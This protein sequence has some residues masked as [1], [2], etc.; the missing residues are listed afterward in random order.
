MALPRPSSP[1]ALTK[2][3]RLFLLGGGRHKILVAVAAILMPVIIVLGFIKDART[4]ILPGRSITY[5]QSWPANRSDE[6]IIAQQKID[7]KKKEIADAKR[8]A[9]WQRLA[10]QLGM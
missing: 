5:I 6:E 10:K 3:L 4:N 2:D 9:E 8:R 7:Q 1:R